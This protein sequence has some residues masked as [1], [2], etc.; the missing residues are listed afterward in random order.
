MIET[1][2]QRRLRYLRNRDRVLAYQKLNYSKNRKIR[3]VY[4]RD[5]RATHPHGCWYRAEV[6]V[7]WNPG[8]DDLFTSPKK[9][10]TKG[11]VFPAHEDSDQCSHH[12]N[13]FAYPCSLTG[14][15]IEVGFNFPILTALELYWQALRVAGG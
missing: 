15:G 13:F 9:C 12:L 4:A 1:S 5:H 3:C 7:V 14:T 8:P 2:E 10:A 11:C 6:G